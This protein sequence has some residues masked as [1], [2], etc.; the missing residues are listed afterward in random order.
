M[1]GL[2]PS[3]LFDEEPLAPV[4]AQVDLGLTLL[5]S[6][7]GSEWALCP[8][9]CEQAARRAV[10]WSVWGLEVREIGPNQGVQTH[11]VVISVQ[12]GLGR[13]GELE[14]FLGLLT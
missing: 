4:S 12:P 13:P 14:A 9:T 11:M 2:V 1:L 3:S 8:R 10:S 7:P 5:G 6:P